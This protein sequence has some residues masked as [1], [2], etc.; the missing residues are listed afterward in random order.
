MQDQSLD[1][2]TWRLGRCSWIAEMFSPSLSLFLSLFLSLY[3]SIY[4]IL[5]RSLPTYILNTLGVV[6]NSKGH[7]FPI[8]QYVFILI[9]LSPF[10]LPFSILH[11]YSCIICSPPLFLSLS[12]THTHSFSSPRPQVALEQAIVL[13]SC[14]SVIYVPLYHHC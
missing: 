9:L 2:L 6:K 8:Y 3:L 7:I 11:F 14:S 10:L 5:A 4:L 1:L 12:L 13:V